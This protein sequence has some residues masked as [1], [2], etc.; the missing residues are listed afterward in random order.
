MKESS[1]LAIDAIINLS[2][3]D[4]LI[5][6]RIDLVKSLDIPMTESSFYPSILGVVLFGIGLA[7]LVERFRN[8][9]KMNGLSIGGAIA[10][11]IYGQVH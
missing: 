1:L 6:F 11:N 5:F 7:L 4:T 2:L 8:I 3:G 9:L 10:T